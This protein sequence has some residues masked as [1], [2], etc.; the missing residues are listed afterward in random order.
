[1]NETAKEEGELSDDEENGRSKIP[2]QRHCLSKF[3]YQRPGLNRNCSESRRVNLPN[4]KH[5]LPSLMELKTRPFPGHRGRPGASQGYKT[6]IGQRPALFSTQRRGNEL[7]N[8]WNLPPP[9]SYGTGSK[10]NTKLDSILCIFS[11]QLT[12][13]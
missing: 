8:R 1:M 6:T 9:N 5:V 11:V 2:Q 10:Y 3:S 13:Y 12:W 4:P 7:G